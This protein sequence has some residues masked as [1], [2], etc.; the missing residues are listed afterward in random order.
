VD[1][2]GKKIWRSKHAT[3]GQR[4]A[5]GDRKLTVRVTNFLRLSRYSILTQFWAEFCIA[6]IND[7][8]GY[9]SDSLEACFSIVNQEIVV[10]VIQVMF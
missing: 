10:S 3:L 1:I 8:L 7:I 4:N 9:I 6:F 5:S 2:A